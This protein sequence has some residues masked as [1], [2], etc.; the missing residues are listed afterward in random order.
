ML[1]QNIE[2][3]E[4]TLISGRKLNR[5]VARSLVECTLPASDGACGAAGLPE[6]SSWG[7][8]AK[9]ALG[10]RRRDGGV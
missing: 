9:S 1:Q 3:L 8:V 2:I 6:G 7:L 4:E 5:D 10:A